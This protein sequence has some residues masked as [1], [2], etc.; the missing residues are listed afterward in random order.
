MSEEQKTQDNIVF[1]GGKPFMNYVTGVIMQFTAKNMP[2]VT[3]RSRGKF[4]S[5]AIDVAEVIRNKFL[6]DQK[7]YIKDIK[8]ESEEFENKEGKKVN[9]SAM[10]IILAKRS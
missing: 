2:E 9:V 7:V 4:T 5:K 1:I 8:I 10:D 6:K 3:I